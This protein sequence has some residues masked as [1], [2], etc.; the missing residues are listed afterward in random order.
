MAANCKSCKLLQIFQVVLNFKL[1][2]FCKIAIRLFWRLGQAR[3]IH[4]DH[5]TRVFAKIKFRLFS[6]RQ[7]RRKKSLCHDGDIAIA[8]DMGLAV[9]LFAIVL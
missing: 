4:D 9:D 8:V 7:A 5:H 6:K 2:N 1:S 3:Q